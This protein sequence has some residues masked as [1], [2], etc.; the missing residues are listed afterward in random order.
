LPCAPAAERMFVE[1]LI[2]FDSP[3][4]SF[5]A[6][7]YSA[8]ADPDPGDATLRPDSPWGMGVYLYRYP[9][10]A[11]G[12]DSMERA[13]ALAQAAGVKWSREEIRWARTEPRKGEY[14]FAFYDSVVDTA[15]KHGISVYGLLSYWS[16]W[17]KAYTEEGIDDFC[18]WAK[19]LVGHFKDRVK[20]WEIYNEPNIFFWQGPK[21]L[22]PVLMRK[23]YTAIKEA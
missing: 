1:A 17:T 18:V 20:H 22:Y 12:D 5:S 11:G 6:R 9:D 21:E 10:P 14:D 2:E 3:Q 19:A 7:A 8:Q 13:A 23:C 15:R 4:G 16:D